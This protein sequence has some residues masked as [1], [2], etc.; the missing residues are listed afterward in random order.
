MP[1][2]YSQI[3]SIYRANRSTMARQDHA[4]NLGAQ[5]YIVGRDSAGMPH[6]DTKQDLY[7]Q[8]H[9][10]RVL[11]VAPECFRWRLDLMVCK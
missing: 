2:K 7:D 8:T 4:M 6:P 5:F 1:F 11:Q 10:A 9:G 3:E